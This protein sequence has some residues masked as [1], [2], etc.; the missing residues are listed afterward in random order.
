[1]T[2]EVKHHLSRERQAF[3]DKIKKQQQI[4]HDG[5]D[6]HCQKLRCLQLAR[7][8]ARVVRDNAI[9]PINLYPLDSEIPFV[10]W[11]AFYPVDSVM[12]SLNNW[13]LKKILYFDSSGWINFLW[14]WNSQWIGHFRPGKWISDVHLLM[15]TVLEKPSIFNSSSRIK[16]SFQETGVAIVSKWPFKTGVK[17]WGVDKTTYLS[18][19]SLQ[20]SGSQCMPVACR[21]TLHLHSSC[22]I[23]FSR[24]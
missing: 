17:S 16:L 18:T 19:L 12:R 8:L 11:R 22:L 15:L 9:H 1:M 5:N 10:L 24:G 14:R 13:A 6:T 4:K 2:K 7:S 23:K 20:E 21:K 3:K